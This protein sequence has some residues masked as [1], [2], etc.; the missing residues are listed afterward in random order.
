[1]TD[2][3]ASEEPPADKGSNGEVVGGF[4]FWFATAR[5]EWSPELYRLHGYQPGA[6]EPTTELML[7]HKH[8]DDRATV[9]ETIARSIEHGEAFSGRHRIIDT[10]GIE[11]TVL[12][13]ADRILDQTGTPV[14]THGYYIDLTPALDAVKRDTLDEAVP[15][16]VESRAV[17][18]QAKG[19]LMRIY[20]VDA[21]Q[22]FKILVWR[23]Q[24]TNTRLRSLAAQLVDELS[25][26]TP[27]P[28]N[29][30]TSF[31]HLLLTLHERI[32]PE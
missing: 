24:E 19:V 26:A 7:E 6:V 4:Q 2:V 30:V 13:V 5:W 8:P 12:V 11:H 17:I 29:V 3:T 23:S 1:M 18:E 20:Q 15:D 22:A 31:D 10:A 14:G 25:A 32:P 9:A 27:P 28:P 16:L 21:E